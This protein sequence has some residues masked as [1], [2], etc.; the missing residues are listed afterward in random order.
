MA[1]IEKP[2]KLMSSTEI[3]AERVRLNKEWDDYRRDL[4]GHQGSPGEWMIERMGE[5]NTEMKRRAQL[6]RDE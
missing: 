1:Y 5:L 2:A 3:I 4:D 6:G